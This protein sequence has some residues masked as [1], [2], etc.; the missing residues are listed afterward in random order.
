M[1]NVTEGFRSYDLSEICKEYREQARKREKDEVLPQR[2]DGS[3]V[4]LLL[5]IKNT[6]MDP[7]LV[8]VLPSGIVCVHESIERYIWIKV[9]IRRTS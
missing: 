6:N 7:V 8:R 4:H 2:V 9:D 1:D 5:G 3:K